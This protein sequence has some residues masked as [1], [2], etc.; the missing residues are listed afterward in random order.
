MAD[1]GCLSAILVASQKYLSQGQNDAQTERTGNRAEAGNAS[2]L[3][4][5]LLS[6]RRIG[7]NLFFIAVPHTVHILWYIHFSP[8]PWDGVLDATKHSASPVQ[9]RRLMS[10]LVESLPLI[11]DQDS[12]T[13]N[14]D[15]LC[16]SVYT[17]NPSTAEKLPV[18]H[19]C[20]F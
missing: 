6:Y 11:V 2:N 1:R 20:H 19:V 7:V 13:Y 16:L 17:T 18:K 12:K 5:F 9:N 14:E 15:C 10:G 8:E 4:F 3:T